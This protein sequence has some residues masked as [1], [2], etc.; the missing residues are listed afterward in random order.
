MR[1]HLPASRLARRD[2]LKLLVAG[3]LGPLGAARAPSAAT[4]APAA[5]SQA[6]KATWDWKKYSGQTIRVLVYTGATTGFVDKLLGE[7]TELTGIRVSWEKIGEDQQRQKLQVE[8]TS[9]M[10]DLDSYMSHTGQQGKALT[11]AGWYEPL[12]PLINDTKVTGP[13]WDH[14]DFDANLLEELGTVDKKLV[15]ILMYAITFP[16]YYRKDLFQE[17]SISVPKTFEEMEAAAK[18]LTDKSKG[19]F[20]MFLRGQP[21]A[22]VGVWA[23]FPY[24]FGGAWLAADGKAQVNSAETVASID[25]YGR[26][27]REYGPPGAINLN[28]AQL[29]DM[30]AQGRGAMFCDSSSLVAR[31]EDAQKSK[32]IDKVGYALPR[33]ARAASSQPL[34]RR[35]GQSTPSRKRRRLPGP[36]SS[37][38]PARTCVR[39]C[40]GRASLSPASRPGRTH[41]S[42]RSSAPSIP[43]SPTR[44]CS[45]TPRVRR[46][47][48][49]F[50]GLNYA[51]A[52]AVRGKSIWITTPWTARPLPPSQFRRMQRA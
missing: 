45:H 4:A 40:S 39:G 51:L 35:Y 20:G 21:A 29:A 47:G 32:V 14:A 52:A 3:S 8:L 49:L 17:A 6:A 11:Q 38:P 26:L 18:K 37:G 43:I 30:F 1:K 15:G 36:S 23:A 24:N 5:A 25:Y 12:E 50:P 27:A 16:L 28:W 33:V 41:N 46:C 2:V 44:S 31:W 13:D 9:R 48:M 42:R 22:A 7:F 34:T 10:T 19:Q